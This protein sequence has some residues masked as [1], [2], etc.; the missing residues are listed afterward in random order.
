MRD[1]TLCAYDVFAYIDGD[2]MAKAVTLMT[3]PDGQAKMQAAAN[4]GSLRPDLGT[5]GPIRSVFDSR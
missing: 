2:F 4:D 3:Q 5:R 1:G